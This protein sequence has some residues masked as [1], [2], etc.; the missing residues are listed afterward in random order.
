MRYDQKLPNWR[1]PVTATLATISKTR[2]SGPTEIPIRL[3]SPFSNSK[4]PSQYF[5]LHNFFLLLAEA[6]LIYYFLASPPPIQYM[7][8]AKG[9]FPSLPSIG[10]PNFNFGP[11]GQRRRQSCKE[12]RGGWKVGNFSV[13]NGPQ[14]MKMWAQRRGLWTA[15]SVPPPIPMGIKENC[16][17]LWPI[18]LAFS[19]W[20]GF[21]K[22]QIN[23]KQKSKRNSLFLLAHLWSFHSSLKRQPLSRKS[24]PI[25]AHCTLK[26]EGKGWKMLLLA[27]WA[28]IHQFLVATIHQF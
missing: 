3:F 11:I 18:H 23:F 10:R 21:Q 4:P 20:N 1:Q 2:N 8:L 9:P 15:K 6:L 25:F 28:T 16:E 14:K 17:G 5:P 19:T 26:K 12:K 22:K 24:T 27:W 13:E 7:A